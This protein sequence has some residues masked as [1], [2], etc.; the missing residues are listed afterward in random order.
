MINTSKGPLVEHKKNKSDQD[1]MI[2]VRW[3][4]MLLLQLLN[5]DLL[6]PIYFPVKYIVKIKQ[7][8]CTF[9]IYMNQSSNI[10]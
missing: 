3:Q 2:L 10:K 9:K 7:H 1:M 6:S 8:I 5:C 4:V